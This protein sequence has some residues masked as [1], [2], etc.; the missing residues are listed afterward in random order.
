M[1]RCR[2]ESLGISPPPGPPFG[3][4]SL[5]HALRAG[6][7]CLEGSC[8]HPEDVRVLVNAGVHRDEHVCEPAIAAYVQRG[9][10]IN[11]E[12]QGRRTLAFDLLNG[13]CGMLNAAHVVSGLLLAGE[14]Q[15]GMVVASE[16][17]SDRRPDPEYRYPPSGAALM[18][19]LSPRETLGF[20][21]FAF[22]THEEHAELY[23]SVVSLKVPRGKLLL[24]R[25][26]ELESIYLEKARAV[27]DEVLERDRL[28]REEIALVVPAQ[29]SPGFLARLPEA[30]GF[31]RGQLAD[32]SD[33][34]E[35]TLT[36]SVFLAMDEARR[37]AGLKPGA[38]LLL[39]AFGSGVTVAAASY[40]L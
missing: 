9:L 40:R 4:G 35:D 6:R 14:A 18:L 30:I 39:L 27:V 12:F 24:R 13:G 33:R 26:A 5:A 21:S 37:T 36:T 19:D 20:G 28:R 25:Q 22:H 1:P 29:L 11:V 23:T 31:G 8:Y 10:G 38:H 7:A 32:Y 16:A 3:R 17:N 34:L 2:I 15:V